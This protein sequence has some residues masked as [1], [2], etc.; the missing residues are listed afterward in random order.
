MIENRALKLALTFLFLITAAFAQTPM[1]P[2]RNAFTFTKYDLNLS[3]DPATSLLTARGTV[4]LRNDSSAPQS[5]VAMQLSSQLKW[6]TIKIAGNPVP[7][8]VAKLDSD[9]D[10][11]G[12]VVE[13]TFTLPQPLAP[14]ATIDIEV[15]YS[16]NIT[17]DFSRLTRVGVPAEQAR[18]SDWDRIS[19]NFTA[20]R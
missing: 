18:A 15:G 16:G 2:D 6:A 7:F 5:G 20:L 11:T 12:A 9:I 1:P 13:A 19:P 17:Q 14:K 8:D 4:T 10:H 3:I